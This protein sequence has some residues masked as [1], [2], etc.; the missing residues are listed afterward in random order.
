MSQVF[1]VSQ[2]ELPGGWDRLGPRSFLA[3]YMELTSST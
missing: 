2:R 1:C 3:S